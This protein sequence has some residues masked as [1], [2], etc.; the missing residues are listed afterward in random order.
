VHRT[1]RLFG[2]LFGG[3]ALLAAALPAL[4]AEPPAGVAFDGVVTV[5]FHDP[6]YDNGNGIEGADVTLTVVD[7]AAPDV[8]IQ[9]EQGTTDAT[10]VASFTEIA[11]PTD[12]SVELELQATAVRDRSFVDAEGCT[13]VEHLDGGAS[14]LAGLEVQIDVAIGTQQDERI[15]PSPVEGPPIIVEGTAVEPDGDP[16]AI[17]AGSAK[18]ATVTGWVELPVETAAD[19]A[20]RVEVP[21]PTGADEERTLTVFLIGPEIR[22]D[23]DEEGCRFHWH[24]VAQGTWT[25]V[26]DEAPEPVTLVAA[27]Q[28]VEGECPQIQP[29]GPPVV[30]PNPTPRPPVAPGPTEPA[31]PN[32]TLPPSDTDDVR[33]TGPGGSPAA[34]LVMLFAISL[35]AAVAARRFSR[36]GS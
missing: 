18:L 24:L 3:L 6:E 29:P 2:I 30:V 25:L 28:V 5:V 17:E 33:A 4:A 31:A 35:S 20:F 10:G 11:R 21:A 36:R 34:A 8:V 15:C 23:V 27:E 9:E 7:L 19:G 26:G 32:T 1:T 13:V 14:A 22:M 16:L 12:P